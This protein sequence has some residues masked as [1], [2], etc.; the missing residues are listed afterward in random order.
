[1]TPQEGIEM[2]LLDLG[3][4]THGVYHTEQEAKD[5]AYNL[6]HLMNGVPFGY[7]FATLPRMGAV[8]LISYRRYA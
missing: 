2:S 3:R 6:A 8:A 5:A 7:V 1:M 4:R